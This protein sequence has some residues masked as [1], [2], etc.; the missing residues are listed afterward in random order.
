VAVPADHQRMARVTELT[1]RA[2]T[3]LARLAADR[4]ETI[5]IAGI[6]TE[7]ARMAAAA[8]AVVHHRMAPMAAA[9]AMAI[10]AIRP[11]RSS[12]SF[13]SCFDPLPMTD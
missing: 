3:A 5:R 2:T 1:A 12:F 11:I 4:I 9:R 7:A 6:R 10:A 8:V 13:R